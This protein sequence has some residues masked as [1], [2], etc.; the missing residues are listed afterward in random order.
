M[1]RLHT[2]SI[3]YTN[4]HLF[5]FLDEWLHN[6]NGH[7][8]DT[9]IYHQVFTTCM[10][11]S[12]NSKGFNLD[13]QTSDILCSL[14]LCLA[15]FTI[16]HL[17]SL[18]QPLQWT[19]IPNKRI[20]DM[21]DAI[22]HKYLSLSRSRGGT[23][24][25]V[26]TNFI[27][28]TSDTQFPVFASARTRKLQ[29]NLQ[30]AA[31]SYVNNLVTSFGNDI[32]LWSDGSVRKHHQYSGVATLIKLHDTVLYTNAIRL[33]TQDIAL[34]EL[35]GILL[36]LY[37]LLDN[38][39]Q[40]RAAHILCDN[41]YAIKACLQMNFPHIK[42]ILIV[43]KILQICKLLEDHIHIQF[44]WI[45]SHTDNISHAQV[46]NDARHCITNPYGPVQPISYLLYSHT[47]ASAS[48]GSTSH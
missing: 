2:R 7:T 29:P 6:Q 40:S 41:Q 27:P 11:P 24:S 46:D 15:A 37:W 28:P 20:I 32:Q 44:H 23:I 22:Q 35:S 1:Y 39:P 48:G 18:L 3:Y 34:T 42:H 30:A 10:S 4:H 21:H 14:L 9:D 38:K 36:N 16:P 8:I 45:P 33:I 12:I 13:S 17:Q 25:L 47:D 26:T 19:E 31:T 5:V 43:Q